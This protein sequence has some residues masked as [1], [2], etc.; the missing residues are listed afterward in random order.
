MKQPWEVAHN[1]LGVPYAHLGRSHNGLDCVGLLAVVLQDCGLAV[2]DC[3]I[4]GTEPSDAN[5]SYHLLEYMQRNFGA[6][7]QRGV[8]INDVI[9][10][11]LAPHLAPGHVAI[12][13]PHPHGMGIIHTRRRT[14]KVVYHRLEPRRWRLIHEVYPWPKH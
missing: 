5:N 8:R 12:V 2:Q 6:P 9:V 10:L 7:V 1:Y 11:R 3:R 13:A 4:Y 14:G